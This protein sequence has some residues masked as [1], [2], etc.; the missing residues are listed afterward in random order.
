M[1]ANA[2]S[3][4][5]ASAYDPAEIEPRLY[6]RWLERGYFHED[7]DP[8]RP[9][10]VICMPPPN[11]TGR[12]HLG[13][14][15]TYTPM[16]VLT[17]YHRMLGD[18]ADWLPGLDHA[19]IATESVIVRELAKEGLDR[20]QLGRAAYL[21]RAWSWSREYGGE[22]NRA[23][24]ILGYSADWE[25]ERFTLD[26][27]LSRAVARVFVRLYDDGLIYRGK[28]LVN[29]DPKART[30]VSDAEV[31]HVERDA[32]LWHVR[33]PLVHS[34]ESEDPFG[35]GI[36]IATTRPE[37]MLGDVAV[38]VHPH[39]PRYAHLVGKHVLLPPLL[40]RAIP[41]IADEAVDPHF[42]TGAVKI[43]PAHDELD[44]EIGLRHGLPMPSVID[45]DARMTGADVPIGKYV[46]LDRF[47][48]RRV[49]LDDLRIGEFLLDEVAH[50]HAVSVSQRSGEIIE[51]LLSEQWFMKVDGLARSALASYREGRVRFVPERYGRSYEHRLE[52]IRDWNISRQVWWGHQLP[53]WY[54]PDGDVVV[55]EDEAAATDLAEARHGTRALRRDPDTLDTWFSSGIWPFSI[56]GWPEPT[57]ELS[58]WYPSS[59]LVTA[60]EIIFLWVT[61]M[62][63]LGTYVMGKEP[64][65]DVFIAPLVFDAE[66]RKM[67]KSLG[68][69]I[70]PI[71]LV[72]RY[73]ADAVRIGILRQMR[74]E[75][76]ELRFQESRCDEA[77]RFNNKIWNAVRYAVA[78]PEPL[79]RA[80]S[81]PP[82][83]A[84]TLAD[85]WIL[86][87]LHHTIVD[88]SKAL[89]GY[90]FGDATETVW[91]FW[92]YELCDWYLEA[93]KAPAN[94]ATRG[95]VL[96]FVL[97]NALR[98]LHPMAPFVTEELWLA[99]PHDGATIMTA[100]W[101]DRLEVPCDS[102]AAAA[103]DAVRRTVERLRNER[104]ENGIA[105]RTRIH[106][107]LP[108]GAEPLRGL[109]DLVLHLCNAAAGAEGERLPDGSIAGY[110][111]A[112]AVQ[113]DPAARRSRLQR[114]RDRL[115]GEVARCRK[116]LANTAFVDRADPAV[117]DTERAK[118]AGYEADLALVEAQLAD[119]TP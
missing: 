5:L 12:A 18:N 30:T 119:P 21:E 77:R 68:N 43:T 49:L 44:Y 81:L 113:V 62:I 56:L 9:P 47:E 3:T 14:G 71:A 67:S 114:E 61:R 53:V 42:G 95:A 86:T 90:D 4:P 85:R 82:T 97:N 65:R 35:E 117:V 6:A 78:L 55:A 106:V 38:A 20:E 11:V 54:T 1:K 25:R 7:P 88:V 76:Q 116:K 33:Y 96:S 17:R 50:R 60:G 52:H 118:L 93:S 69:A 73:G 40:E 100:T 13:H 83:D 10:F 15:S 109:R 58:C 16:D 87:R 72:E 80:L 46:G 101:P 31:E 105:D 89:D 34:E 102:E 36:A 104:A 57:I 94:H 59:V 64:F 19:A 28:R 8:A 79:P 24:R 45:L 112:F 39:D 23:F 29:W 75:A 70:D 41:I 22:I 111:D 32:H 84:L 26:E 2:S 37:T 66:G 74:L 98:L 63:M 99:L 27:G 48:A 110:L 103:F 92:W 91:R 115:E 108:G 51:P 107:V